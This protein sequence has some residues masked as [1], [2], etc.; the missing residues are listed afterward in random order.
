MVSLHIL[1][2]EEIC[3]DCD[4]SVDIED[5][6]GCKF[7]GRHFGAEGVGKLVPSACALTRRQR[8]PDATCA[9][10]DPETP[11]RWAIATRPPRIP[12]PEAPTF[13]PEPP[14]LLEG[15]IRACFGHIDEA[16]CPHF[17]PGFVCKAA[18]RSIA[19]DLERPTGCCVTGLKPLELC[20]KECLETLSAC[21][22]RSS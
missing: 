2:R 12:M 6:I 8:E 19:G 16:P 20:R 3:E 13:Y 14:T 17:A 18:N 5:R 10:P 22:V 7:V 4:H 21:T 9:D 1:T 11:D 15:S